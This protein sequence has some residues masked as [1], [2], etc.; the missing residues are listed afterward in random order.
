MQKRRSL[1]LM[2]T[3]VLVP[4]GV[5]SLWVWRAK[6]QY[7]LDRQLIAALVH[8]DHK[9]ALVL[10]NAG[11]DPNTH[12][13]LPPTPTLKHLLSRLFH[14]TP[15][16]VPNSPTAFMLACGNNSFLP[17]SRGIEILYLPDDI[18]LA[19]AM[20]TCGADY[21]ITDSTT[22]SPLHIAVRSSHLHV[23]QLLLEHGANVNKQDINKFTPLTYAVAECK[24]D[25]TR[26][27][28]EHGANVSF[29][30]GWGYAPLHEAMIYGKDMERARLLLAHGANPY[31]KDWRGNTPIRYAQIQ[32]RA[33][34]VTLMR[35]KW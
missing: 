3:L 14:H 1:F 2:L 8:N 11:A 10:V 30:D 9:L 20:L 21:N 17:E 4:A 32:R 24:T 16:P 19:Q 13:D 33:D 15:V 23:A 29:V 7:A 25:M 27:L 26:L 28:L 5:G 35:R 34:M 31:Q 6:R 12:F 22:S 18:P